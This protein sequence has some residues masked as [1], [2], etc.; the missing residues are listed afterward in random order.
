MKNI[1]KITNMALIFTLIGVF[2]GQNIAYSL[3]TLLRVPMSIDEDK[4]VEVIKHFESKDDEVGPVNHKLDLDINWVTRK[5]YDRHTQVAMP[6]IMTKNIAE[7]VFNVNSDFLRKTI[8]SCLKNEIKLEEVKKIKRLGIEFFQYGRHN[9]IFRV[10]AFLGTKEVIFG[11]VLANNSSLN[12]DTKNDFVN[13]RLLREQFPAF[14]DLLQNPYVLDNSTSLTMFSCEWFDDYYELGISW[15]N[16]AQ[17]T[18][19]YINDSRVSVPPRE[20]TSTPTAFKFTKK[21]TAAIVEEISRMLTIFFDEERQRSIDLSQIIIE[22]GDFTHYK[23]VSKPKLKLMT[24]RNIK[25]NQNVNDF[26]TVLMNLENDVA[27]GG[28]SGLFSFSFAFS[29]YR[30]SVAKGILRGLQ[31]KHGKEQGK[32]R[33]RAWR[34][35]C[36]LLKPEVVEILPEMT[37]LLKQADSSRE[38]L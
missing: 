38:D 8:S 7:V 10:V 25:K 6:S 37:E 22:A 36:L 33:F 31:D 3:D 35:D 23:K 32:E 17:K 18:T 29:N 5:M 21:A 15:N 16:D 14:S 1:H 34:G 30:K 28:F 19:F 11:L 24:V 2:L 9:H 26:I 13:I 20:M 12:Q 4:V 27:N